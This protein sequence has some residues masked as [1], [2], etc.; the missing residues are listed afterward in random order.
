MSARILDMYAASDSDFSDDDNLSFHKRR[1]GGS[2]ASEGW[3]SLDENLFD[4]E[5][6]NAEMDFFPDTK[7]YNK[8]G[9]TLDEAYEDLGD[10][11]AFV[12]DTNPRNFVEYIKEDDEL[13]L[14]EDDAFQPLHMPMVKWRKGMTF[15]S[16]HEKLENYLGNDAKEDRTDLHDM[17][18]A[19]ESPP[20]DFYDDGEGG[21]GGGGGGGGSG[22]GG[23]GGR[24]E[25]GAV[26]RREASDALVRQGLAA[27]RMSRAERHSAQL[28]SPVKLL[29][30]TVAAAIRKAEATAGVPTSAR[31][32][33]A[34]PKNVIEN[35]H[36]G[37]AALMASAAA[38]KALR[39]PAPKPLTRSQAAKVESK[40]TTAPAR[41]KGPSR[42]EAARAEAVS[43]HER[44][45]A[46]Q[47]ARKSAM[48]GPRT[49]PNVVLRNRDRDVSRQAQAAAAAIEE[50]GRG[51]AAPPP[52]AA[53]APPLPFFVLTG[54]ARKS[55][56]YGGNKIT[57]GTPLPALL[58]AQTAAEKLRDDVPNKREIVD[59]IKRAIRENNTAAGA[60]TPK[61]P[62]GRSAA[63]AA[64]AARAGGGG[65]GASADSE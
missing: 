17:N 27:G 32:A 13:S 20:D 36:Y 21:G 4:R 28:G 12:A 29:K 33:A 65:G 10:D 14:D 23:G 2:V 47:G 43:V 57:A 11:A 45:L 64:A 18:V 41:V 48:V 50:G 63:A 55:L 58:V 6:G 22:G 1:R 53:R 46:A 62:R 38:A 26:A 49:D 39:S 42:Q 19:G 15:I 9:L 52:V 24:V 30:P 34:V 8:A 40:A 37:A 16:G 31:K 61:A 7:A 56:T 3:E 25:S 5:Q 54:D 44:R 59:K 60:R 51:A 35:P